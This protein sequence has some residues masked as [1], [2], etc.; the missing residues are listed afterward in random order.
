MSRAALK[1]YGRDLRVADFLQQELAQIIRSD[2]RDPRV[3]LVSVNDVR[4]SKDLSY[5]DVYVTALGAD[6][7]ESQQALVAVLAKAAGYFRSTLAR[8]HSMRTTPRLRFHH[9]DAA[10][11]GPRL[12][13]LIERALDADEAQKPTQAGGT[14]SEVHDG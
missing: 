4:V 2:M 5:A 1:D 12:E 6:D 11:R 8:R 10:I 13:S 14:D 9:D 7:A 3:G